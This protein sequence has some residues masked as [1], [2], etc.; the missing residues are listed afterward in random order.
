[1]ARGGK[2]MFISMKKLWRY[3]CHILQAKKS[4][5]WPQRSE[6]L[7]YNAA[8]QEILLEYTQPWNPETLH[9]RREQIN[10]RVL[11]KSFLKKEGWS[12]LI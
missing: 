10:M 3:L 2:I 8:N 5:T 9:V 1:M 7:I 4:W 11:L 6:V 12:M